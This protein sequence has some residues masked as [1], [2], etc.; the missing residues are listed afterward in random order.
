[1]ASCRD[2][3]GNSSSRTFAIK[4]D[5]TAPAVRSGQAARGPDS[6]SWYNHPVSIGFNGTDQT[7]GV[8]ACTSTAFG[9]PDSGSASVPGTCTDNA[10]NTSGPFAFPL[11]YDATKP[12]VTAAR[13][14]RGADA[15]GWYNRPVAIAFSGTD[16]TSGVATCTSTSYGGP[17]SG[18]ASVSGSCT[19]QAGNTSSSS[20]FGL[21]YDATGPE[22]REARPDR[23][24]DFAG[25]FTDPVSFDITGADATSGL[26][27][28]P[29]VTYSGPD[30]ANAGVRAECRDMA[31]NSG[32]RQFALRYD[33]TAPAVADLNA[34]AGDRSVSLS[35]RSSPD[36]DSVE[37]A[38]TPG[39]G[40]EPATVVF[41]GPGSA[42]VDAA[43][44]NGVSY[45]YQVTV[46]DPAG[47]A[48]S[49]TVTAVPAALTVP[50]GGGSG[51]PTPAPVAVPPG[52]P[53][54]GPTS[55]GHRLLAPSSGAVLRARRPPLLRWTPVQGARYYNVQLFR[56]GRKIL[57]AWPTRP[58]YQLKRR[59]TYRGELRRLVP[60]RYR[61][62]VWPGFGPRS[63]ADY[64]RR[65]GPGT[66]EVR[67]SMAG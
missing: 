29:R 53:A 35:W 31:G 2:R 5:A 8:N 60:G 42:F 47:N 38:R 37:V 63:K 49:A 16:Q 7:S 59:W 20:G 18:T 9:G 15:N 17:D 50:V 36:T 40:S 19:D 32:S 58:R 22:V 48:G 25:W 61:W 62:L 45:S 43:V 21:K 46:R 44:N 65:M 55:E 13:P 52:T 11:K 4:Y 23:P 34:A 1:M 67:R 12:S 54:P 30:A 64:G 3:A 14:A 56:K 24:P 33:A 41:R 39:R 66:F 26:A 27:D 57:S 28:C 6:G 10:G 51:A